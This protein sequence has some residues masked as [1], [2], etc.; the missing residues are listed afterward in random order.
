MGFAAN[1]YNTRVSMGALGLL[2]LNQTLVLNNLRSRI[3]VKRMAIENRRYV[4]VAALLG[5]EGV[6]FCHCA[7]F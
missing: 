6:W 4:I 5:A 3:A 7:R 2:K 1:Q